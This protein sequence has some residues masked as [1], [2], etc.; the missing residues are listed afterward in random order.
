MVIKKIKN[1]L[2]VKQYG[3]I[4]GSGKK[5]LFEQKKQ[6]INK[7]KINLLFKGKTTF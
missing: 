4:F 2:F 5:N 3:K 7:G 1:N 6:N